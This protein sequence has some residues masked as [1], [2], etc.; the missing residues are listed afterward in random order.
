VRAHLGIDTTVVK[1]V[2]ANNAVSHIGKK[3]DRCMTPAN[4][5]FCE[6]LVEKPV[7]RRRF[8]G[9]FKTLRE[10]AD[11]MLA[12]IAATGRQPTPAEISRLRML[13]PQP[14]SPRSRSA[15]LRS[16]S[17]MPCA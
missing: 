2:L 16:A 3:A 17:R 5:R 11:T 14:V 7:L 4:R 12:Q 10:T 13:G 15:A 8:L 1:Q 6:G 9:S